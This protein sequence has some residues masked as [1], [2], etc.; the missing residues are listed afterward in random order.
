MLIVD[1]DVARPEE[2]DIEAGNTIFRCL[3]VCQVWGSMSI[4]RRLHFAVKM[5]FIA[6]EIR[7]DFYNQF[8]QFSSI[9]ICFPALI[10]VVGRSELH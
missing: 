2:A 6:V 10:V 7:Q 5:S 9:D 1:V 8:H 4:R 3:H